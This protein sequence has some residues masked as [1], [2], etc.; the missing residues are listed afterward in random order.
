MKD[1]QVLWLDSFKQVLLMLVWQLHVHL[2]T[3]V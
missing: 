2:G 3:I 1:A